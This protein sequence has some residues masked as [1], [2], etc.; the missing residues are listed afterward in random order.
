MFMQLLID[1]VTITAHEG[2]SVGEGFSTLKIQWRACPAIVVFSCS[3]IFY[4]FA[5]HGFPLFF[6]F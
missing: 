3:L 4:S 2:E 5:L 6:Y 1:A